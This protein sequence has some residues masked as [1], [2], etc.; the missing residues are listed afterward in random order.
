MTL[1]ARDKWKKRRDTLPP[2][3]SKIMSLI[4]FTQFHELD[5]SQQ[6]NDAG[7][8]LVADHQ[9]LSAYG[10]SYYVFGWQQ[11]KYQYNKKPIFLWL[12][13]QDDHQLALQAIYANVTGIVVSANHLEKLNAFAMQQ[14]VKVVSTPD[15]ICH[16]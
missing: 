9:L 2:L 7:I 15:E 8:I 6:I 13:C 3:L 10:V 11:L 16:G 12:D 5:L 14:G 1:K 4:H